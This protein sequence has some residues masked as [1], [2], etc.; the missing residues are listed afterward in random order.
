MFKLWAEWSGIIKIW[1]I[2]RPLEVGASAVFPWSLCLRLLPVWPAHGAGSVPYHAVIMFVSTLVDEPPW[3]WCASICITQRWRMHPKVEHIESPLESTGLPPFFPGEP[4]PQ[5]Q[6][7]ILQSPA[8][9]HPSVLTP[10]TSQHFFRIVHS[11]RSA[12]DG[13][14]VSG[15]SKSPLMLLRLVNS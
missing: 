10:G 14:Q 4:G 3:K 9:D 6:S 12:K 15:A 11:T 1:W 7:R 13:F 2:T 5:V 8:T